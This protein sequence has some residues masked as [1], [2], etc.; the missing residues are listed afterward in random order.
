MS[1]AA[2]NTPCPRRSLTRIFD[3]PDRS[4]ATPPLS[5]V[6]E[7]PAPP[8]DAFCRCCVPSTT[9]VTCGADSPDPLELSAPFL[10]PART[11]GEATET[12]AGKPDRRRRL[13]ERLRA[14]VRALEGSA[15]HR[16][17][18]PSAARDPEASSVAGTVRPDLSSALRAAPPDAG[19]TFGEA[20]FDACLAGGCLDPAA[21]IEVKPGDH[22]DWPAALAFAVCLAV[23]RERTGQ[24]HPGPVVS[25]PVLWCATRPLLVEHGRLHGPGLAGLGLAPDRLIMVE[26]SRDADALWVLE[27]AL[28]A[29]SLSLVV[30]QLKGVDL[31]PSRRLAL[32]AASGGTPALV[33]TLPASPPA[34]AAALRLRLRRLPG[35]PHPF[36]RRAPGSPRF[37]VTVERCRGA[38]PAA[39]NLSLDLEW[40]DVTY[41]FRMAADV[42]D[43]ADATA[44]ARQRAGR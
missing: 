26:A 4:S 29:G 12:T 34:P 31:T 2:P 17:A 15:S 6:A 18:I 33:L 13:I 41:R 42:A 22:G 32:A 21:L 14:E 3:D 24:K 10:L 1:P 40:C 30:G 5:P 28:R 35:P 9:P 36:D 7:T 23:R 8:C 25:G 11:A 38:P 37:N 20:A 39:E 16:L 44:E 27:E 19:W 43:R